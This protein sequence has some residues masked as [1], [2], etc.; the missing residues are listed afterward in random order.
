[1]GWSR[2]RRVRQI[3]TWLALFLMGMGA[4]VA[5]SV[6]VVNQRA[7]T[8]MERRQAEANQGLLKRLI[9]RELSLDV[10]ERQAL[11]DVLA[12][13]VDV[14]EVL[15]RQHELAMWPMRRKLFAR[16]RGRLRPDNQRQ[17]DIVLREIEGRR[18]HRFVP[19]LSMEQIEAAS[20]S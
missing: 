2:K 9:E 14:Y 1:M 8:F 18:R 10:R 11:E 15:L 17:L 20:G 16:L 12:Q 5:L 13:N 4:G 7:L 6:R 19:P 3:L